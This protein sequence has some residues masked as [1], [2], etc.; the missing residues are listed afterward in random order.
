MPIG[1]LHQIVLH[2]SKELFSAVFLILM[3]I[4]R[5]QI[6]RTFHTLIYSE[7]HEIS[8]MFCDL[9]M[10]SSVYQRHLHRYNYEIKLNLGT[11]VWL[12]CSIP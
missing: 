7:E 11:L 9:M 1:R 12:T 10:D 4:I 6:I 2:P 8:R 5:T 3:K